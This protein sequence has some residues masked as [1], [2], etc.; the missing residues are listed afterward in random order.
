MPAACIFSPHKRGNQNMLKHL[1]HDETGTT[2]IEYGLIGS[3]L[4]IC[5]I[6]AITLSGQSLN[7]FYQKIAAAI[8]TP[9]GG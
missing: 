9:A 1:I 2:L 3:I 4:A 7:Q 5:A 6:A 8:A